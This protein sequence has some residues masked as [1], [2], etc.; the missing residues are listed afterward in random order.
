MKSLDW[1][2]RI[3]ASFSP[4]PGLTKNEPLASCSSVTPAR[5][6]CWSLTTAARISAS[7]ESAAN[8]KAH[9]HVAWLELGHTQALERGDLAGQVRA[10]AIAPFGESRECLAR[11]DRPPGTGA[12]DGGPG[13][14]GQG[15]AQAIVEAVA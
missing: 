3:L 12:A 6:P 8:R 11:V 4:I 15:L 9:S 13:G 1:P 10:H 7:V 2:R 5:A 14:S